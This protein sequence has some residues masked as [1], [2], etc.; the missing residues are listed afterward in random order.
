MYCAPLSVQLVTDP[1][2][3]P[4]LSTISHVGFARALESVIVYD[5]TPPLTL[6]IT[7]EGL[8][9][10]IDHANVAGDPFEVPATPQAVNVCRPSARAELGDHDPVSHG[11]VAPPSS[12]QRKPVALVAENEKPA[13][14]SE[15][16][17]SGSPENA[18]CPTTM[19]G[20][21]VVDDVVV[22]V[23]VESDV[24]VDLP[25]LPVPDPVVVLDPPVVVVSV[26]VCP[27]APP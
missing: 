19:G 7:T 14:A 25:S 5:A 24:V 12:W 1:A 6:L 3:C 13:V 9:V 22:R 2:C 17:L 21:V 8:V 23:L 20:G 15:V 11:A 26:G 4:A 16:G 10:S 27:R 18:T